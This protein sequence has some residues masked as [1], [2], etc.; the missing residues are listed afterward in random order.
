MILQQVLWHRDDSLHQV[1]DPRTVGFFCCFTTGRRLLGRSSPMFPLRLVIVLRIT[2]CCLVVLESGNLCRV[3]RGAWLQ[4]A[5]QEHHAEP[6]SSGKSETRSKSARFLVTPTSLVTVVGCQTTSLKFADMYSKLKCNTQYHIVTECCALLMKID[7]KMI[8]TQT[9]RQTQL[10]NAASVVGRVFIIG[11]LHTLIFRRSSVSWRYT[12]HP[13]TCLSVRT[14]YAYNSVGVFN[15]YLS[16][17]RD[18]C[19]LCRYYRAPAAARL[20]RWFTRKRAI[21]LCDSSTRGT[22]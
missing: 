5:S 10:I 14:C 18:A 11:S 19:R 3:S 8:F 6:D 12:Q 9:V 20:C 15:R 17:S 13:R 2:A 7:I 16:W 1:H 21:C 22:V 4:S